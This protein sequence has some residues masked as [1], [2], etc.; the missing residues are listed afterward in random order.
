MSDPFFVP[1]EFHRDILSSKATESCLLVLARGLGID[2]LIRSF[3]Y[4]YADPRMLV[5]LLTSET[6][7]DP[8]LTEGDSTSLFEIEISAYISRIR[9]DTSIKERTKF[10][11]K[12]GVIILSPR[13]FLMDLLHG[14]IPIPLVTGVMFNEAHR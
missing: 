5:F 7:D 11:A 4:L 13:V 10:Y 8:A 6:E 3:I 2:S 14:R 9:P 1:I 12:G